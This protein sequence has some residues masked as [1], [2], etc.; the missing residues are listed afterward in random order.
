MMIER[1]HIQII[2]KNNSYEIDVDEN[3]IIDHVINDLY[4]HIIKPNTYIPL[5]EKIYIETKLKI[6]MYVVK[7]GSKSINYNDNVKFDIYNLYI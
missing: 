1:K 3:D 2:Y 7:C 6:K 5:F 4:Y